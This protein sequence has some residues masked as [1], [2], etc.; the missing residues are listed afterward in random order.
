M[1]SFAGRVVVLLAVYLLVLTSLDPGDIAIGTLLSIAIVAASRPEARV[2]AGGW[3]PW[4]VALLGTLA[5][6]G[7]EVIIG[8]VRTARF[9]LGGKAQ[10]DF[11]EIPRDGRSERAVALWGLLTGEA[12]DEYPVDVDE[13]R[14]VLVVHVLDASDPAAI[15]ARHVRTRERWQGRVVE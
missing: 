6:T 10:P 11:V 5:S 3:L 7:R 8:T 1:I 4:T 15:R 9:A 13:G 12:P 2:P 14:D